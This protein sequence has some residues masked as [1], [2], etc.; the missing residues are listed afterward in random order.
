MSTAG[1]FD[2]EECALTAHS[3]GDSRKTHS[4]SDSEVHKYSALWQVTWERI[5]CFLPNLRQE[6]FTPRSQSP[7]ANTPPVKVEQEKVLTEPSNPGSDLTC[8]VDEGKKLLFC[9]LNKKNFLCLCVVSNLN[10][11]LRNVTYPYCVML[12]IAYHCLRY[13]FWL[14]RKNPKLYPHCL[15]L[16][17][18]WYWENISQQFKTCHCVKTAR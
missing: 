7:P 16:R 18:V 17:F 1:I 14:E 4:R 5:D 6:L 10:W 9:Q 13:L 3:Q 15:L 12:M 2:E 11:S 8:P